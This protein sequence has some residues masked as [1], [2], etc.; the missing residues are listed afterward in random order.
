[1]TLTLI[2][3]PQE[4]RDALGGHRAEGRT[5]GLVPTMG[6]LH[7]GH[8]SLIRRAAGQRDVVAV[9]NYVNRL[10]FGAGEDFAAYPRDLDRDTQVASEAGAHLMFAPTPEALWPS[11]PMTNVR[12]SGVSDRLEGSARP[13]H[14]D[15]VATI[16]TKLLSLAGPC[17]AFFG[18]KDWQQLAVIRRLAS[19]LSLPVEVIPCPTLRT[20][21]GLALSSRNQYLTAAELKVAPRLYHALLAGRRKVETGERDPA[22]VSEAMH[23]SLRSV[24]EF[25]I[26]YLEVAQADTLAPLDAVAGEVRLLGAAR[27]GRAR[28][29]DNIGAA[30][31]HKGPETSDP[32]TAIP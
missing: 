25:D 32:M 31:P 5:V 7:G 2:T 6:A 18:E 22:V 9:T 29:I 8:A 24:P 15:G 23:H 21:D 4:W 1:M 17:W 20:T 11:S 30:S 26:E 3:D 19:D 10:Q 27:L 12:V 13:G 14:F 16:V 28:L